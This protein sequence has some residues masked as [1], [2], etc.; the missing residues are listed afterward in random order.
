[1]YIHLLICIAY[2]KSI[3]IV[4]DIRRKTDIQWFTENFKDICKT[5]RIESDDSIRIERGWTFV[6]G[7]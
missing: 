1:M 7:M 4:S 3:W 5:I 2:D 6:T